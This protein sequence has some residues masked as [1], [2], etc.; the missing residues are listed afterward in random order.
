MQL[1]ST[2]LE[3]CASTVLLIINAN[4]RKIAREMRGAEGSISRAYSILIF[5]RGHKVTKTKL[6]QTA[7]NICCSLSVRWKR[8]PNT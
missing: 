6:K 8:K 7:A 5:N 4:Q 1:T 3:S 2:W